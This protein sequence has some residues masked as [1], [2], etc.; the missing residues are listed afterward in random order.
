MYRNVN[1]A[2]KISLWLPAG[3]GSSEFFEFLLPEQRSHDFFF[4]IYIIIPIYSSCLFL[5]LLKLIQFAMAGVPII[6]SANDTIMEYYD[7]MVIGRTGM[8]K[9]T[10][11]DKILIANLE[12][13][14]HHQR[15][16]HP[17]E[18]ETA[19]QVM[20]DN[21]SVW[22]FGYA[23]DE[24]ME[25]KERLKYLEKCRHDKN[26]HLELNDIY[27]VK[28]PSIRSQLVSNESTRV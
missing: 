10:T 26:P 1:I 22:K 18:I 12:G 16:D 23:D 14:A 11:S 17:Q 5:F 9:S 2:I 27:K 20:M 19:E 3:F 13:H 24:I 7:V 25:V 28:D 15:E 4:K 6:E 8:G 21:Y